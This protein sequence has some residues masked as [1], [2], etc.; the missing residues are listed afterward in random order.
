MKEQMNIGQG[1]AKG[2][3]FDISCDHHHM[4]KRS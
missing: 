3:P 1:L 4:R 2:I